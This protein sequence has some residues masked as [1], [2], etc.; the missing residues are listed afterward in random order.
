MASAK[1]VNRQRTECVSAKYEQFLG[2][3]ATCTLEEEQSVRAGYGA[4]KSCSCKGF[5]SNY[6][7]NDK[8]K[9]CKHHYTQ[10]R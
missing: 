2:I 5:V 10:H 1:Y 6:P 4:C 9:E 8:C 3:A 7:P